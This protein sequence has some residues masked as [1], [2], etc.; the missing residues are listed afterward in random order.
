MKA[1]ERSAQIFMEMRGGKGLLGLTIDVL[2]SM[3]TRVIQEAES[4]KI[5][6]C[7]KLAESVKDKASKAIAEAIREKAK[8][9]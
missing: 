4:A 9:K 3:V 6:E 2:E 7:A 8:L 5:E 1:H